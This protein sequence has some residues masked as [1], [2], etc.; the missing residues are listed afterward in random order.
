MAQSPSEEETHPQPL[1]TLSREDVRPA[2]MMEIFDVYLTALGNSLLDLEA[3]LISYASSQLSPG[4]FEQNVNASYTEL[5]NIMRNA[6]AEVRRMYAL[7]PQI[8]KDRSKTP[9]S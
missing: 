1:L 5:H 4:P 6:E 3:T 9:A 2:R 8:A 7:S